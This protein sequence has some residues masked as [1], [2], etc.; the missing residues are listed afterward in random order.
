M[1]RYTIFAGVNGAGK[2]SLYNV[3]FE[4][5]EAI[6]LR[7][8]LDEIVRGLGDWRD[9]KLQLEAGKQAVRL[10]RQY[11]SE[12]VSFHQETTLAGKS[13]FRT[14]RE[15]KKFGFEVVMYY[16]GLDTPGIAKARVLA[17]VQSGGHGVENAVVEKRFTA[18]LE[19]LKLAVAFCDAVHFYDNSGE[20]LRYVLSIERGAVKEREATLPLWLQSVFDDLILGSLEYRGCVGSICYSAEGGCYYGKIL[21]INDLYSY[22]GSN[23]SELETAFHEAVD[24]HLDR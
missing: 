11:L 12:G 14:I 9:E 4:H 20:S 5:N 16:V 6:G 17:R 1:K 24:E 23:L 21:G 7:V 19:H 22:K 10:V 18:A 13:I 3:A 2:T 15:A 8:N